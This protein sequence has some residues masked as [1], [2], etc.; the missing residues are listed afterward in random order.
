[1]A[2]TRRQQARRKSRTRRQAKGRKPARRQRG[3]ANETIFL[4]TRQ[5]AVLNTLSIYDL[6]ELYKTSRQNPAPNPE[7]IKLIKLSTFKSRE[8]DDAYIAN[9]ITYSEPGQYD[10]FG[11]SYKNKPVL[12][13]V[14]KWRLK[15][16]L[17]AILNRTDFNCNQDVIIEGNQDV[18]IEVFNYVIIDLLKG[19][20]E[21]IRK[22][23][24]FGVVGPKEILEDHNTA[25]ANLKK[26]SDK[27]MTPD[28][29]QKLQ[30]NIR[31]LIKLKEELNNRNVTYKL[32]KQGDEALI[33]GP[34]IIKQ[35]FI[36]S[37]TK[38]A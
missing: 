3:G 33:Y 19:N 37:L 8:Q 14:V 10:F 6:E 27:C 21:Y 7:L 20:S 24:M 34:E 11:Y 28:N 13:N 17:D 5:T 31:I 18:I 4:N 2:K 36:D 15:Q 22:G 9:K 29:I 23:S 25:L 16:T 30:S 35:T 26:L 38:S 1:M 12:L 32:Q